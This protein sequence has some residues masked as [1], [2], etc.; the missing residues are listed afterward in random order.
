MSSPEN[1]GRPCSRATDSTPCT[2]VE[3]TQRHHQHRADVHDLGRDRGQ[4]GLVVP[5]HTQRLSG[6]EHLPRQRTL[7]RHPPAGQH[8]GAGPD[9]DLDPQL[10][11]SAVG[12]HDGDQVGAARS[13]GLRSAISVQRVG[14]VAASSAVI[15]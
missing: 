6:G 8:I 3:P 13:P 14:R 4:P 5:C 1:V 7:Q 15:S 10:L 12:K 2:R 11:P 9:R